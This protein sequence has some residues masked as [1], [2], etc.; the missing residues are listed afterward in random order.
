MTLHYV[1][2]K[3]LHIMQNN[4]T[5]RI[6]CKINYYSFSHDEEYVINTSLLLLLLLLM[7]LIH[8]FRKDWKEHFFECQK[9]KKMINGMEYSAVKLQR[10]LLGANE[11]W[12]AQVSFLLL[13]ILLYL[14]F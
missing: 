9:L 13:I 5:W 7:V 11:K 10:R 3:L 2:S 8:H 14:S 6:I 1:A 4:S 12:I